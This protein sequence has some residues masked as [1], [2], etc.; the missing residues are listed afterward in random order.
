MAGKR[1]TPLPPPSDGYYE[2]SRQPLQALI[3]LLPI[4]C[5][6]E[7][8][9]LAYAQW[10]G[11]D[12]P[13]NSA[14]SLLYRMLEWFGAGGHYLP[15]LLV[16][17]ILISWHVARR[18]P[19]QLDPKLYLGML[20]ESVALAIP[21]LVFALVWGR[22]PLSPPAAE[23][24]WQAK[25]VFSVGAGIYEELLFRLIAI[26]LLHM[27]LVDLIGLKHLH[28]AAIAIGASAVLFA[29]YHFT[30]PTPFDP[31]RFVFYA[32]AGVYLAWLYILRGFGIVV[33]THAIYDI[34]IVAIEHGFL[35]IN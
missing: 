27:I 28:G 30:G 11:A 3:F 1:P 20:A 8:G 22:E 6:Y 17:V 13:P 5:A 26:A 14:W 29:A 31:L 23:Y 7:V 15:G 32:I 19:W 16:V 34:F 35:P 24:P 21:I 12:L 10:N 18:D 4:L 33:A 25:L 9:M 2:R